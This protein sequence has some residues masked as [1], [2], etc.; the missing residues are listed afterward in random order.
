MALHANLQ[1]MLVRKIFQYPFPF[2]TDQEAFSKPHQ[3][4]DERLHGLLPHREEEDCGGESRHTQRRDIQAAG[5][6]VPTSASGIFI[7][8]T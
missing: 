8:L 4:T 5:Q 6:E 1:N 7:S 3:A 2:F